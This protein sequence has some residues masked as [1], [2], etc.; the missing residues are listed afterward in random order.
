MLAEARALGFHRVGI[1]PI[2]PPRR[3]QAYEDWL[4]ADRHGS[5][6]YMA[7]PEHRRARADLRALLPEAVS[8]VVVAL[9]YAERGGDEPRGDGPHGLV[10]RYARGD[11][12]HHVMKQK[13]YALADRIA[14]ACGR[15]VAAR[16]CVDSAPVL[17]RELAERAGIGF[18]AKNT[19]LIAPGLGSYT[20]L[21]ELLL[22]AELAPT[23]DQPM[24]QRCGGCR[25]CLDVCPTGA[26]SDPFV[27]DAR[28]CI[29]YL[30]IEHQGA[31]PEELRPRIGTM[32][33]GCDLCQEVCPFNAAAPART[34]PAP[35]L[36]ARTT[37]RGV[38]ALLE[39]LELGANQRRRWQKHSALR[40]V[41]R[42]QL[43]R[44][45]CVALG[46]AGDE[47]A[48]PA[49]TRLA[50]SD[51]SELV[52]EHAAWA[53]GQLDARSEDAACASGD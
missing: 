6:A 31:I 7:A 18:V 36:A 24:R 48:R 19:M 5:M 52:R 35:E 39:L 38:P 42:E 46:N 4:A 43:V 11:D 28:R 41:S 44:N 16:P 47:R 53:L 20:L 33:F 29:S 27:L 51:P 3:Y 21:G 32:I 2:E 25:A 40:R 49:L 23:S 10:A 50:E 30:T 26:F 8:V 14:E 17:E 1:V 34:T 9:A 12:Y 13:L 37:D 22:D 15:Q 45:V